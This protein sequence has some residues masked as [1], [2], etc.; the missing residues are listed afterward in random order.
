MTAPRGAI[1]KSYGVP[2]DATAAQPTGKG[3]VYAATG[4]NPF[5]K[6]KKMPKLTEPPGLGTVNMK[7][8][9]LKL[10]KKVAAP[11][12][13]ENEDEDEDDE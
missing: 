11:P 12:P 9:K 2:A 1:A 4:K 3:P 13:E 7:M 8:K 6:A 5:P 10:K